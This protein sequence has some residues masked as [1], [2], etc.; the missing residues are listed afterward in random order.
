MNRRNG[1]DYGYDGDIAL[2]G[3]DDMV[4]RT[5]QENG[6]KRYCFVL[7]NLPIYVFLLDCDYT[8]IYANRYFRERF[9]SPGDQP[10]Y[11]F[12]YGRD[13]PC[14]KCRSAE[15]LRQRQSMEEDWFEAPDNR[16]YRIYNYPFADSDGS[17]I[18]LEVGMD[19]TERV[20]AESRL[21]DY[22]EKLESSNQELREFAY[23]ASHDLQEPL[24]EITNF[25]NLIRNK[26][27]GHL[28]K[29]GTDYLLRMEAAAGRMR[30][31]ISG[32]LEYS[33]LTTH[34]RPFKPVDLNTLINNVLSDIDELIKQ[35]NASVTRESLASIEADSNQMRQL[36]QNLVTNAIKFN[37]N[38]QPRVY[39]Q[40]KMLDRPEAPDNARYRRF[41]RRWYRF[42]VSDNGFG[43]EPEFAERIFSPFQR[44]SDARYIEG[45]GIGLSICRRIV[46]R[47]GGSITAQSVPGEGSTFVVTLPVERKGAPDNET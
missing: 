4:P 42:W 17:R 18:N 11:R 13:R 15:V 20:R 9:G 30:N 35:N 19:I 10:C 33:R 5:R 12:F 28:D 22:S 2:N 39:I 27:G 37:E 21:K 34:K 32:L 23:V 25:S 47:H 3:P 29:K 24:R 8:I 38:P 16:I 43:F 14:G 36:F 31:L 45:S 1:S 40:G 46:A 44:L 41:S 26:Y 6:G 7:E